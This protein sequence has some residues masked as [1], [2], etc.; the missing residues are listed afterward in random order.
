M[1]RY[2]E[3][4]QI[5]SLEGRFEYLKCPGV[6]GEDTFGG[7]RY[8]NQDFYR[9]REWQQFRSS[10]IARDLGCDMAYP[11]EEIGGIIVIHH[12]NPITPESIIHADPM[13]FDPENVVCVS[14]LTHKL[15]HYG[16][17]EVFMLATN[18][19][20]RRPNDTCPWKS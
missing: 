7:Y 18:F 6:V 3:L 4:I 14:E 2:S 10:I 11:G 20:E 13:I 8:L 5:P 17:K 16:S 19:I 15:I 12:I 9:S 1:K